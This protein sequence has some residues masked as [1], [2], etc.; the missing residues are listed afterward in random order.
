M[1]AD[2]LADLV[3]PTVGII[4]SVVPQP[5]AED[6]PIP[7]YLYVATLSHFDFRMADGNERIGAG[8]GP[9]PEAAYAAAIGEA[10]ERY[11]A[12]QWDMGRTIV[13]P[14]AQVPAGTIL[15]T[16]LVLYSAAQYATPGFPHRPWDERADTTWLAGVELGSGD[17]VFVPAGM[18][19]LVNPMPTPQDHLTPPTSNGL[20]AGAT[21]SDAVLG[22]LYEL[23]E[24][25][26]FLITWMNRL[27]A[28]EI[29]LR[30]SGGAAASV[31]THYGRRGVT[32]RAFLLPSDL[33]AATVLAVAFDDA[34][35][36]PAQIVGLGCHLDVAVATEKAVFELCQARPS[37]TARFR[38]NPPE[39]RLR[40]YRD[41]A[42]LDDH[43]AFASQRSRRHEFEF[44]WASGSSTVLEGAAGPLP[45]AEEQLRT[46]TTEL[47]RLGS[48]L[49]Y[50]DLTLPDIASV[51]LHVVRV[52]ATSLQPI[53]FGHGEERL[54]GTRLFSVPE[55]LGL[56][57]PRSGPE[58]LN[59]CPHPLA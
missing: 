20:A 41:V 9:S 21:L 17:E 26:A 38:D 53:H 19:Y 47:S 23:M 48:R 22:G 55:Q 36:R 58:E 43:S 12:F 52:L 16:D 37:E 59:P 15:P 57:D 45:P 18:T 56:R 30:A 40:E 39:G 10:V 34:P 7:P 11:C 44:L 2:R 13:V 29:D 14:A 24:R 27:P 3:S 8:K 31:A 28:T 5:R 6:E 49:A 46:C 42:T 35:G 4:R 50:V 33:P 25:D 32:L 51:G 54:G 1:P